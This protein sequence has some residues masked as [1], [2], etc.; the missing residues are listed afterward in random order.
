MVTGLPLPETNTRGRVQGSG[1]TATRRVSPSASI[2]P[3]VPN[4]WVMPAR[5]SGQSATLG[6]GVAGRR[7]R[8]SGGARAVVLADAAGRAAGRRP[9]S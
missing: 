8:G 7:L 2:S 4:V 3:G 6:G 9:R 1:Q 5:M